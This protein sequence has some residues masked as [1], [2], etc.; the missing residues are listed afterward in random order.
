MGD[1]V[2]GTSKVYDKLRDN[3][4]SLDEAHNLLQ[5]ARKA[6]AAD[7][8][9]LSRGVETAA[10]R[11]KKVSKV[12]TRGV[13]GIDK[14]KTQIA[15]AQK[16][17]DDIDL[18]Y[19]TRN[20]K[21]ELSALQ[22]EAKGMLEGDVTSLEG[23]DKKIK[24]NQEA[25]EKL[26]GTVSEKTQQRQ[27][28]DEELSPLTTDLFQAQ[29]QLS[30]ANTKMEIGKKEYVPGE[31]S[32]DDRRQISGLKGANTRATNAIKSIE[33]LNSFYSKHADDFKS[34]IE[35]MDILRGSD[36]QDE[37]QSKMQD[38]QNEIIGL[39]QEHFESQGQEFKDSML[40]LDK[41]NT[42]EQLDSVRGL[43]EH[44][45]NKAQGRYSGTRKTDETY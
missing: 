8:P 42:P 13:S 19:G 26:V 40:D 27:S 6:F 35:D 1:I 43:V 41:I 33:T 3:K 30:D 22:T 15:Q 11:F 29:Q 21:G 20:R 12:D 37:A 23:L 44:S 5:N 34:Y 45:V 38:R 9:D 32:D 7:S 25:Y 24:S 31:L 28:I 17:M 10:A 18:E 4:N 39:A 16:E 14:L 36:D 2:K